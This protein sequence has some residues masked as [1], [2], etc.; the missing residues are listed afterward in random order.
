[1]DTSIFKVHSTKSA[2][3]TAAANP[4][5]TTNDILIA[6]DCMELRISH[7]K[8]YYK[9]CRDSSFGT[10]VLS[11]RRKTSATNTH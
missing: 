8:F 10:A 2:A 5:L 4:G 7:P 1:M 3:T 9:P 11:T 6:A